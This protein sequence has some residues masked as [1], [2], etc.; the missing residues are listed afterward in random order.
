MNSSPVAGLVRGWVDLYTRGLPADARAARRDEIDDDLWCEHAEAA[1]AGRSARSLDTD[2]ALRL[3]FGVPSDISW[4]LSYRTRPPNVIHER[5]RSTST[6]ILGLLAILAGSSLGLLLILFIPMGDSVWTTYA[7]V[8]LWLGSMVSF[9]AAAV[10]LAWHFQ[11][12]IGQLGVG[13]AMVVALAFGLLFVAPVGTG[14]ALAVGS[15]MLMW[16]LARIGVLSRRM[17]IAHVVTAI[18]LIGLFAGNLVAPGN[19]VGGFLIPPYVVSWI[20]IGVS[21]IR[22]VP[23]EKVTSG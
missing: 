7:T 18:L 12:R 19:A 17:A 6:S 5:Q 9:V 15:A 4:R 21:L 14:A 8:L 13:G 22:G 16:G 3:M 11:D 2:L 1:A 23:Q 20:A 10:G